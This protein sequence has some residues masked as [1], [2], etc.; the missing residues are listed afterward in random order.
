MT[1][2]KK[3]EPA[4]VA[5]A[6]ETQVVVVDDTETTLDPLDLVTEEETEMDDDAETTVE[7]L[8]PDENDN[9][10]DN[11]GEN[12]DDEVT[13]E[14][15]ELDT[16]RARFAEQGI[17]LGTDPVKVIRALAEKVVELTPLAKDGVAY[18]KDLIT[19]AI[20][21]GIRAKGD[22]F[23]TDYYKD[24]FKRLTIEDIKV[25]RDD[26]QA[27]GDLRLTGGTGKGG[28]KTI[29]DETEEGEEAPNESLM[30]FPSR[31]YKV[32]S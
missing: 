16:L 7:A 22:A 14:A 23:R 5:D 25:M 9:D 18:R 4:A 3:R 27:D 29:L 31:A 11:G 28:R 19:D 20:K 8:G 13:A 30:Q 2:K 15:T 1:T 32:G 10:N 17:K 26:W 21:Q 6:E 24:M 12:E